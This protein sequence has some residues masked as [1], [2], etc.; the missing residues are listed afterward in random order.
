L[1]LGSLLWKMLVDRIRK[2]VG[3]GPKT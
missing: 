2:L 1:N 3:L